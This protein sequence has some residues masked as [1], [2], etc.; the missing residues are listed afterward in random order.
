MPAPS[1]SS[2]SNLHMGRKGGSVHFSNPSKGVSELESRLPKPSQ[3]RRGRMESE[4]TG[5]QTGLPAMGLS[6]NRPL[7]IQGKFS[8]GLFL[9]TKPQ[10]KPSG[11]RRLSPELGHETGL[12]FSSFSPNPGSP[13]EDEDQYHHSDPGRTRLVQES[14]VSHLEGN[15][16][17]RPV[18][19]SRQERSVNAGTSGASQ[20]QQAETDCLDPERQTLRKKGLSN[21]EERF[22]CLDVRRTV[23]A[24]IKRTKSWRKSANLL[25]QFGG[26]NKGSK[27]SKTSLARWIKETIREC[28][29]LQSSSCPITLRAHSTRAM[30]ATWAEKAGASIDQICRAA[31]W[32]SS[33]T[34]VR[35]YRLDSM[36]NQD[37]AFG[38]KVLQAVVP[39]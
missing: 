29:R 33:T 35:H 37:L 18:P 30:S 6:R 39:P 31:T 4:Q 26:R 21:Q 17:Q 14:L 25:I 34:F 5:L 11:S 22:H 13:K 2:R 28:Y 8:T 1:G 16:D 23:L 10:R 20:S 9:L 27:A 12:R 36:A 15:V 7:R 19:P 24:Y 32:S 3:D 38:R